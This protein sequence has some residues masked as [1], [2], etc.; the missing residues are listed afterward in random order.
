MT[1]QDE[2]EIPLADYELDNN[3]EPIKEIIEHRKKVQE[4]RIKEQKLKTLI[5]ER[6]ELE[7][8]LSL[9]RERERIEKAKREL[10]KIYCDDC[11]R[12]VWPDHFD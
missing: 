12:W 3:S 9:R 1:E 4:N 10:K 6:K 7:L 11:R 5:A 2:Q 8:K